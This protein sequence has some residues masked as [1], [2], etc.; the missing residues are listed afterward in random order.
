MRSILS[1]C[2]VAILASVMLWAQSGS[3]V[4]AQQSQ[5]QPTREPAGSF[6]RPIFGSPKAFDVGAPS[7]R[8]VTMAD[9]NGD[10]KLDLLVAE[11]TGVA[12]LLGN[13]DGTFQAA[14]NYGSGGI[15]AYSVA[16][17]DVDRDG[18]PDLV[19]AN[20]CLYGSDCPSEGGGGVG[21]LLGNGDGTFGPV[22]TYD[23][24]N[25]EN[26][27]V[28]LADLNG[29][30]NLDVVVGSGGCSDASLGCA[31]G[32]ISV[33][34]GYGDGTFGQPTFYDPGGLYTES[35]VVADVNGD[36]KPDVLAASCHVIHYV[37]CGGA[38]V[39]ELLGNGDG[40]FQPAVFYDAGGGGAGSLA[41]A[42][43]N[44]DSKLDL[45][46]GNGRGV[47]EL[48]GN[49]DGSFQMKAIQLSN[50]PSW[51]AV[52]DVNGDG[53]I[54]LVL[55][56]G[57]AELC[58]LSELGAVGVALGNADETFQSQS[59][60]RSGGVLSLYLTVGDLNGDGKLDVAVSNIC[61]NSS[62]CDGNS[63]VGVL[64]NGAVP[65]TAR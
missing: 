34:L 3:G 12:V 39:A 45:L 14:V 47:A 27:S 43:V 33:L 1:A 25:L 30:G 37:E 63:T 59:I 17:G 7:A 40:T 11:E 2:F 28:V 18:K 58:S 49:G 29:D 10:G 56:Y 35:V 9:V 32:Q 19:V 6:R 26:F 4:S 22:V 52:G 54:D 61:G 8:G 50:V 23:V 41:L 13:G 38:R 64:L 57:C 55:D 48:L 31:A 46:V 51:L 20:F 44:G 15:F 5:A 24:N 16:V 60:Y 53:K 42:D 21:V 62:T 65:M 36:G